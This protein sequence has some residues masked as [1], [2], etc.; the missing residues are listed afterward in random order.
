[1]SN[2]HMFDLKEAEESVH[3][4]PAV[5]ADALR[6]AERKCI[7][8]EKR[9]HAPGVL[10]LAGMML[11]LCLLVPWAGRAEAGRPLYAVPG[12]NG[13]W[14]Y[15][16]SLGQWAIAPQF[17]WAED[18]RGDYACASMYPSEDELP[19]N[20]SAAEAW[21]DADGQEADGPDEED[22]AEDFWDEEG[23]G[24]GWDEEGWGADTPDVLD[25][26][27]D[28]S[29][30][31][32]LE[33][34][35]EIMSVNDS[36]TFAGGRDTGYFL[37]WDWGADSAKEYGWFNIP[38]GF[39]SGVPYERVY[40]NWEDGPASALQATAFGGAWGFVDRFTGEALLPFQE[41]WSLAGTYSEGCVPVRRG[42]EC[43]LMDREGNAAPLPAGYVYPAFEPVAV[44]EGLIQVTDAES[45]LYGFMDTAG[46]IVIAPAFLYAGAFRDGAANVQFPEGDYGFVDATGRVLYRGAPQGSDFSRGLASFPDSEAEYTMVFIRPD[47]QEAFRVSRENLFSAGSFDENGIAV[48]QVMQETKHY[49]AAWDWEYSTYW[50]YGLINAQGEW[51]TEP[52]FYVTD[53]KWG[54]SMLH[55]GLAAMT[56]LDTLLAGYVD[57]RGQ[58]VIQPQFDSAEEFRDGLAKVQLGGEVQFIDR[59]GAVLFSYAAQPEF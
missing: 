21:P 22:R 53:Q 55:D 15:I 9:T 43:A 12:D 59:E 24:D 14:G 37:V 33:P 18:F 42:Q 13:K 16:D 3:S 56:D 35:Y 47:G 7:M 45:G 23:W 57:A 1:M 36:G 11:L 41:E 44:S 40:V 38:N 51:L 17:D 52:I 27:I 48:Y 19:E 34:Q 20:E 5:R 8:G 49:M 29:G 58:W 10:Q 25:G 46:R 32:V 4:S 39:F 26:I 2:Y 31:W 50:A 6:P 28:L 54:D 30:A